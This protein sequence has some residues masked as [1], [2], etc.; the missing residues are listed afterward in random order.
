MKVNQ[1]NVNE[2]VVRASIPCAE[3]QVDPPK[4]VDIR[5]ASNCRSSLMSIMIV[6]RRSPRLPRRRPSCF[7]IG[8]PIPLMKEWLC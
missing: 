2:V 6:P 1:T 4:R 8:E 7:E 5:K 3:W